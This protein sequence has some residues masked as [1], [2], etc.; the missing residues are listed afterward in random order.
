MLDGSRKQFNDAQGLIGIP[1]EPFSELT[2]MQLEINTLEKL[3]NLYN[4]VCVETE[5]W[6]TYTYTELQKDP[7]MI[8]LMRD[9][10]L[11]FTGEGKKLGKDLKK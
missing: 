3:Y 6:D 1:K 5:V 2:K 8:N 9:N 7:E 11:K 4:Q 10:V